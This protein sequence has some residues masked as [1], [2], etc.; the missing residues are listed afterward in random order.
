MDRVVEYLFIQFFIMSASLFFLQLAG[1]NGFSHLFI[2][3]VIPASSNGREVIINKEMLTSVPG[4]LV[5]EVNTVI[6]T[7]EIV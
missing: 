1:V 3:L 2:I 4:I 5:K 6:F 7:S